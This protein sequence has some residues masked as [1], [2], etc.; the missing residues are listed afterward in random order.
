MSV[1]EDIDICILSW[2]II[3]ILF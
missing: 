3:W 1:E 2:N